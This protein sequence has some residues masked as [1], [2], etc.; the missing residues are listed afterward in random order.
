MQYFQVTLT[1]SSRFLETSDLCFIIILSS[2]STLFEVVCFFFSRLELSYLF[3]IFE[4]FVG[5]L[6]F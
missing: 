1:S 3:K 2:L 5:C 4:D 6:G